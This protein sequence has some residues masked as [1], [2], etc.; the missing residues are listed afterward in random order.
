LQKAYSDPTTSVNPLP[1]TERIY[2]LHD[3]V[4]IFSADHNTGYYGILQVN[5]LRCNDSNGIGIWEYKLL[6]ISPTPLGIHDGWYPGHLLQ[7]SDCLRSLISA[8]EDIQREEE[9]DASKCDSFPG[10]DL[11]GVRVPRSKP[12]FAFNDQ[13]LVHDDAP[14]PSCKVPFLV[15]AIHADGDFWSYSLQREDEYGSVYRMEAMEYEVELDPH[16]ARENSYCE[17]CNSIAQ[18]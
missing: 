16:A 11:R 6:D 4:P 12:K 8:G 18:A 1:T 14:R 7:S 5:G 13:V 2:G 9:H 3:I 17:S 15:R 10:S